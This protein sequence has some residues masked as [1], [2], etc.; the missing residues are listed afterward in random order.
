M[1]KKTAKKTAG[2]GS[3]QYLL[4]LPEGVRDAVANLAEENGRSIN[5]EIL[6]AIEKHLEGAGRMTE[7][8]DFYQKH[9]QLIE[10][11]DN[12]SEW[13]SGGIAKDFDDLE[14]KISDIVFALKERG[15]MR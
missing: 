1:A 14:R 8:W 3:D 4:R 15:I 7:M 9:R 13:Y 10:A 12:Y 11:M 2:R 5:T 6:A